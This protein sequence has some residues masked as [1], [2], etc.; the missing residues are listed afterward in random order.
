MMKKR[1]IEWNFSLADIS[2]FYFTHLDDD[3]SLVGWCR[4]IRISAA[5]LWCIN[6]LESPQWF[7]IKKHKPVRNVKKMT[8]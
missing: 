8:R 6:N 3:L 7:P 4:N 1:L 5:P 2:D